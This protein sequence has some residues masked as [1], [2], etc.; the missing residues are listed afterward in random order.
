MFLLSYQL[1]QKYLL[2]KS[3][4]SPQFPTFFFRLLCMSLLLFVNNRS[5]AHAS[6]FA[7]MSKLK[8]IQ[9]KA[10]SFSKTFL[11]LSDMPAVHHCFWKCLEHCQCLSF[12]ICQ[13]Q[14][15]QLSS[16]TKDL[17]PSAFGKKDGCIYYSF[18][19]DIKM[20]SN[21]I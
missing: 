17:T 3:C 19:H 5:M 16:T 2:A 9:N 12:Q 8:V 18:A 20:V 15:C 13:N 14:G 11:N 1:Y 21:W 6:G 7:G 4:R 10:L